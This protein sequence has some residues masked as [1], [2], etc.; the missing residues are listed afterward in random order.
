MDMF[1]RRRLRRSPPGMLSFVVLVAVLFLLIQLFFSVEHNLRPAILALA[2]IK[3][4]GLATDAI[5][6]AILDKVAEGIHY[7]DLIIIEQDDEGRIVMAQ[8]NSMEVNRVMADTT[9]TTR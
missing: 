3:A 6:F 5:N 9:I 7:K 2:E 8:L 1:I 4:D